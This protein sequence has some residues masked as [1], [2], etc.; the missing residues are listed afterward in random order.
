MPTTAILSRFIEERF[1]IS[2]PQPGAIAPPKDSMEALFESY[3]SRAANLPSH[4]YARDGSLATAETEAAIADLVGV[5]ADKLVVFNSGMTA[6]DNAI[7]TAIHQTVKPTKRP[8][9][10]Y[11]AEL[12]T[13][14]TEKIFNY[15]GKIARAKVLPFQPGDPEDI[16][17]MVTTHKPNVIVAE[18][19]ANFQGA[20]VLDTEHF[21]EF[22]AKKSPNT[23]SIL[24]NTLPLSTSLPLGESLSPSENIIVVES[25]TKAFGLNGEMSGHAYSQN[26]QLLHVLRNYRRNA[27]GAPGEA[28]LE[29]INQLLPSNQREFDARNNNVQYNAGSLALS[30]HEGQ[31]VDSNFTVHHPA[32]SDHPQ[33]DYAKENL[34]SGGSPV[35]FVQLKEKY[36]GKERM[37]EIGNRI[38]HNPKVEPHAEIGQSF[39]LDKTRILASRWGPVLRIAA[40]VETDVEQLGPALRDAIINSTK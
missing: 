17:R 1:F 22:L 19:V 20:A 18:T 33:Y 27:G 10:L 15:I 14:T 31:K 7:N 16:E 37:I 29:R 11:S 39:G 9:V 25:G 38:A 34:P 21:R 6:I 32:L 5:E 13:E 35:V 28:N 24:D 2:R 26:N 36:L 23:I 8:T 30:I 12:Y 3:E 40:G 4:S